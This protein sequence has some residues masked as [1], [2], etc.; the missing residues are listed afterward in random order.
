MKSMVFNVSMVPHGVQW[1]S[2]VSHGR[3]WSSVVANCF[4]GFQLI[5]IDLYGYGLKS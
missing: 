2:T 3:Q 5:L 4:N 1:F